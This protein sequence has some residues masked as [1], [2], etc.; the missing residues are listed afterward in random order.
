[1]LSE[2]KYGA[3]QEKTVRSYLNWSNLL[4]IKAKVNARIQDMTS[5]LLVTLSK[6]YYFYLICLSVNLLLSINSYCLRKLLISLM[7]YIPKETVSHNHPKDQNDFARITN[8]QP[9]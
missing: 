7:C 2:V 5:L 4:P 1:M 8:L 9:F 3:L 6:D